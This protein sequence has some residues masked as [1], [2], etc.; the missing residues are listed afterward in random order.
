MLIEVQAEHIRAAKGAG[1]VDKLHPRRVLAQDIAD[2][3]LAPGGFGGGNHTLGLGDGHGEG[4]FHKDM[5]PCFHR[6]A[7]IV[8]MRVGIGRDHCE[9]GFDLG[10]GCVKIVKGGIGRKLRVIHF[11]RAIDQPDDFSVRMIVVREGVA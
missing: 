5:R 1:F 6:C 4:F 9:V 3:Q 10:Q 11:A 7:G 8:R 2:H